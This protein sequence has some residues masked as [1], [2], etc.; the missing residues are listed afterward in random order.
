[1]KIKIN[2]T[3]DENAKYFGVLMG[4]NVEIEL[5]DYVAGVVASEIGNAHIEACRAQAIAA[6]TFAWP[7][8]SKGKAISDA[9]SSAQ[10]FRAPRMKNSNYANAIQ[11]AEDTKGMLLVYG[12]NVI[13]TCSYSASNGGRT[14]S[15]EERWGGKRAWLIAQE[16]PWDLAATGGKKSGHGVGMSQ[17]G[18]KYAA[19]NLGKKYTDILGFYYPGCVISMANE[20]GESSM[21]VKA[22]YLIAGFN[23]MLKEHWKY[24]FGS[25][26]KGEVDCSGAF[27]YWY[28]QAGSTM[29]HGSNTMYRKWS[30]EKGKIGSIPLVPGMAVYKHRNDGKEP[31]TYLND[32]IGNMYH[33]GLYVG[34]D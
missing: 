29:Y 27:T 30:T 15:S 10:A 25:A 19:S 23:Q 7:Y 31:A 21:S 24:V 8:V 22:S 5:E 28:K 20:E 18:A 3:R 14:T 34:N 17:A 33:V 16:D 9:S 1:M 6:R 12:G 13:S 4:D 32:G 2:V 26:K 11:S